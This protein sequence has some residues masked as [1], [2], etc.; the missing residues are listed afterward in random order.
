[1]TKEDVIKQDWNE[2]ISKSLITQKEIDDFNLK[3]KI[4]N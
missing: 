4:I 2:F 3:Y 1:M